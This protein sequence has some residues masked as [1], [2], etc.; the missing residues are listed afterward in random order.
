[1]S[2]RGLYGI[3]FFS[4]LSSAVLGSEAANPLP[5]FQQPG[6]D[7][8]FRRLTID[9][10]GKTPTVKKIDAGW[11]KT[12]ADRGEPTVYTKANS[13]NFQYLGMPTGGIGA[14]ELYLGG[15]GKLW[16]WDIFGTRCSAG[17]PVEQGDAFS[18]P[19]TE[20][21]AGDPFQ[22]VVRQGFV[23]QTK[24]AGKTDVRTLDTDGF[25]DVRFRGQYPIGYVDY[26]D[27]SSPVQVHLEAFSPYDPDNV[28]DST[29]PATILNYTLTNSS[30]QAVDCD[31]GGWLE[32]AVA[33]QTRA[34]GSV[35]LRAQS[36]SGKQT[37]M[38]M[39]SAAAKGSPPAGRTISIDDFESGTYDKW[40]VTGTA[41]GTR[42]M[43]RGE[44][45]G[46][47]PVVGAQGGFYVDSYRDGSDQATG[48]LLSKPFKLTL[49]FV[50][51]LLG[52]GNK[53]NTASVYLLV[54][55]QVVDFATGN[56]DEIMRPVVWNVSNYL[57]KD[58]HFKIIDND[59]TGWGHILVD[60]IVQ[61]DIS[62]APVAI[63]KQVDV[64]TLA[65]AAIGANK[66]DVVAQISGP[67]YAR[68]LLN[69]P[70]SDH[71]S[72]TPQ[73]ADA[74][75]VSGLREH[76]TL[77]PGEKKTVSFVVAWYFPNP[78]ELGLRT[79]MR[80]IYAKRFTSAADV[81]SHVANRLQAAE[82]HDPRVA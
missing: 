62:S 29:Y 20:N 26:A 10:G 49:P 59:T 28:D 11:A 57:G 30:T 44:R 38:V 35:V 78:L 50:H 55:G 54:D 73:S 2:L 67:D 63:D 5:E 14:G 4:F 25:G 80:R 24:S 41:F 6:D 72:L 64:G 7:A 81:V 51:F 16:E 53:P 66:V 82:R 56:G 40:T 18:K 22:T 47:F 77:A 23:L 48:T 68:S 15:D 31:L 3:A 52:G 76:I 71:A 33:N 12:L 39:E 45:T 9:S 43:K 34:Q 13:K 17:F 75:L 61:S 21:A 8:S 70:A 46:G 65:L 79:D 32:N 42:P 37:T 27:A 36:V 74:H 19:H 58:A 69:A 1:M 60:S